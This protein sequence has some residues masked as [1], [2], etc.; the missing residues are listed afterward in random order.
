MATRSLGVLRLDLIARIGGFEEGMDKAARRAEKRMKEIRKNVRAARKGINEFGERVKVSAAIAATALGAVVVTSANAGR[1]LKNMATLANATA[2]EFQTT[3]F[4]AR[5]LGIEEDKLAD[6]LKDVNDRVGDFIATGGG[7][8]ADFFENIAPKVGLTANEFKR[9]SG[10]QALQLYVSALE[11]A[12]LNQQDMTFY[13]EA[14]ASDATALLPLLREN[15]RALQEHARRAK[16]LGAVLSETEIESLAH[17]SNEMRTAVDLAGTLAQKYSAEL[18]PAIIGTLN[19]MEDAAVEAGG[20]GQVAAESAQWTI[21]SFGEVLDAVAGVRRTFAVAGRGLALMFLGV[22]AN[23]WN[24]ANAIVNGP[25]SATNEFIEL[26]NNLPNVDIRTI[27]YTDLGESIQRNLVETRRAIQIGQDDIHN[28]LMEPLPSRAIEEFADKAKK[29]I[30]EALEEARKANEI[31][32]TTGAL[33]DQSSVLDDLIDEA[34]A[35]GQAWGDAVEADRQATQ[36]LR[37]RA[38][39]LRRL[40]LTD[41]ARALEDLQAQ[42]R[43][44]NG[45]VDKNILGQEEAAKVA[46]GLAT[47]WKESVD[48]SKNGMD[49]MSEFAKEAARA[50]QEAF[51]DFLFDPFEDG[52]GGMLRG[53]AETMRRIVANNLAASIFEGLGGA[54]GG[55]GGVLGM[56]GGAITPNAFGNVIQSGQVKAFA[57]GGIVDAPTLFPMKSGAGLMGEAGAEA[58]MPLQRGADGRLGVGGGMPNISIINVSSEEE[59]RNYVNSAEGGEAILNQVQRNPSA[60]KAAM[61][62]H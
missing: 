18:A 61:G 48:A 39:E 44:L 47:R 50:S 56:I 32:N 62:V 38:E 25:V 36:S 59:A 15:G 19:A 53:F 37:D 9:L 40:S 54:L 11:Q 31:R 42:Y 46:A 6:I 12:N 34:V 14:I 45:L 27:G 10:P 58:I 60:F 51:A 33:Q 1:E 5:T 24:L 7:P 2:E 22:E 49:S 23:A 41:Q 4:G 52:L 3:A 21:K 28:I 13:M 55:Q 29:S 8:M 35:Y 16:D 17:L 57:Q 30:N 26:L 43:E 20:L